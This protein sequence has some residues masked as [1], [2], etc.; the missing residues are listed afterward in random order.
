MNF[1]L[2]I[3]DRK[4]RDLQKK[5]LETS[6]AKLPEQ[7]V[8][9]TAD[10][11]GALKRSHR[12]QVIA[13]HKRK[14]PSKGVIRAD[15]QP[16]VIAAGYEQSGAAA[17]SVLTDS[18]FDGRA[19]DLIAVQPAPAVAVRVQHGFDLPVGLRSLF[20]LRGGVFLWPL[21]LFKRSPHAGL[22]SGRVARP[23]R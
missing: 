21:V 19:E 11:L 22:P 14:S 1:L 4:R 20:C 8:P 3:C 10:V 18:A 6:L 7:V 2:D 5:S 13:E 17:I 23:G 9:C 12:L 16:A 15:S